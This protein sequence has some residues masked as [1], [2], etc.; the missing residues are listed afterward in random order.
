MALAQFS[1]TPMT[2]RAHQ[3]RYTGNKPN[4]NHDGGLVV[5]GLGSL[6]IRY[7][8][9]AILDRAPTEARKSKMPKKRFGANQAE[10]AD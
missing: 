7:D 6:R 10:W 3:D 4:R 1:R 8:I 2:Q 9:P 5:D